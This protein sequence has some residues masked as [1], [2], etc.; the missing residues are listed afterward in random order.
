MK[1]FHIMFVF[2]VKF[3]LLGFQGHCFCFVFFFFWLYPVRTCS[4]FKRNSLLNIVFIFYFFNYPLFFYLYN[5]FFITLWR[6][7]ITYLLLTKLQQFFH[8]VPRVITTPTPVPTTPLGMWY[9]AAFN[10]HYILIRIYFILF[11]CIRYLVKV[12]IMLKNLYLENI[13]ISQVSDHR[14]GIALRLYFV[15]VISLFCIAHPY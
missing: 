7:Y 9:K 14:H 10:Y 12:I 5:I 6:F 11:Y 3:S 4:C 15:K 13:F 8:L 2:A 1:L